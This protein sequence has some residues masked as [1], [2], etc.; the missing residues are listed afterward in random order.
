MQTWSG[1]EAGAPNG[2]F[3]TFLARSAICE[4]GRASFPPFSHRPPP[5]L[6]VTPPYAEMPVTPPYAENKKEAAPLCFCSCPGDRAAAGL[7]PV[8]LPLQHP[9]PSQLVIRRP[10][11]ELP[12]GVTYTWLWWVAWLFQL[13]AG[14]LLTTSLVA[15]LVI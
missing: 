5:R 8:P 9:H 2:H 14:Q 13:L 4:R 1:S 15:C 6:P 11:T 10:G 12:C 7:V 3:S